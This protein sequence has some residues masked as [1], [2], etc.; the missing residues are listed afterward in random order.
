MLS[1][2]DRNGSIKGTHAFERFLKVDGDRAELV[3]DD[4]TIPLD[5]QVGGIALGARQ[6]I[7]L[8]HP[9]TAMDSM[10]GLEALEREMNARKGFV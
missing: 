6:A 2:Y 10:I 9:E 4:L 7:I 5:D 8:G 1:C 3:E